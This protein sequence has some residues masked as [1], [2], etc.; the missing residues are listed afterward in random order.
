[1]A[2]PGDE[3][4]AVLAEIFMSEENQSRFHAA[5][6]AIDVGPPAL[7]LLLGMEPGVG[8]P[9]R[10]FAD[11]LRCDASWVTALVDDL[12]S[13]GY[14]ERRILPTDRRV[15]AIVITKAGLAAQ[16]KAKRVLHKAPA[17][18]HALSSAEQRKLRDLLV[19]MQA[20]A[21]AQEVAG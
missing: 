13:H 8:T 18:M 15:R 3:A 12:E 10:V 14:V 1:M 16:T 19:K 5:C 6:E 9:M 21:S 17:S 11:K 20:A 4:W 2:T 7:K